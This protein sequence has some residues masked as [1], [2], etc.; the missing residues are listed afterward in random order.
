[1]SENRTHLATPARLLIVHHALA[2]PRR[3][4]RADPEQ[5]TFAAELLGQLLDV[6]VPAFTR[7][8]VVDTALNQI[9]PVECRDLAI[10]RELVGS[11]SHR[12][13]GRTSCSARSL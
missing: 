11:G 5:P 12:D 4:P 1:M 6:A 8:R 7:A 13:A 3:C 10:P 9:V 2:A